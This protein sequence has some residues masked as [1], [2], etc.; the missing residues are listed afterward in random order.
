MDINFKNQWLESKELAKQAMMKSG[1]WSKH[2]QMGRRW[3]V[4]CVALEITQRCN[5]DCS[6]CYLSEHSEAIADI[7]LEEIYKRIDKIYFLYG[8][9]TD[10]QITGGDPT[11][12]KREELIAIVRYIKQKNM[13]STLMTNGIKA[14][15][16]LLTE[17]AKGGLT[18][19]AFHVDTTQNIKQATNE[20]SLN[21]TRLK[22]INNAYAAGLSIM[23][24]TTVHKD[25]VHEIPALVKFFKQHADKI[26]TV[27]FQLQADTGRGIAGKRDIIITPDNIW[28]KIEEG[29]AHSLNH[30]AIRTGHHHCNRYGMSLIINN[31]AY[32]LFSDSE[33]IAELHAAT[34]HIE[35]NRKNKWK[36]IRKFFYWLLLNP[37]YIKPV[38]RWTSS[39][40]NQIKND[41]FAAKGKINNLSFFVHNFMDACQLEQERLDAC[42]FHTMTNEGPVSM[43]QHNAQR[44]SYILKA[45]PVNTEHTV[46]FWHPLDA[47]LYDNEPNIPI[48]NPLNYSQKK[49]KGRTRKFL[50]TGS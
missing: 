35:L 29:L 32:D 19:V 49:L 24:N 3:P 14:T 23:F 26:R 39:F 1:C 34:T 28:Q 45:I 38:Y 30:E 22:Y 6:L 20:L 33:F 9:N 46:K 10:I 47:K 41:L 40:Y 21:E 13:R 11:L 25:N 44:D 8:P 5:L 36:S 7:P 12:R 43:C 18:D 37:V 17:L 2:Q 42:V 50:R 48:Q 16:S 4:G 15:R 31:K 27:S